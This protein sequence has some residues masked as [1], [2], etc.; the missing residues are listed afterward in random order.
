MPLGTEVHLGPGDAHHPPLKG[1]QPPVMVHVYCGQT[2]G[3]MKK[4]LGTKVDLG[5]GHIVF[6]GDSALPCERGTAA[7]L[8]SAHFYCGHGYPSQPLLSSC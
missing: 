5:P 7:P 1:A 8:F 6:D 2:A 4:P 3:W